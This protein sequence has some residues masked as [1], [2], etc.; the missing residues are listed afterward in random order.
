MHDKS[1]GEEQS[2]E[3]AHSHK[4]GTVKAEEQILAV[5]I[6]NSEELTDQQLSL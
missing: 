3:R 5:F 6:L 1:K 4:L 2:R